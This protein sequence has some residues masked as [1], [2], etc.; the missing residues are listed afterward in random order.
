[1]N[2]IK[3]IET[4][5]RQPNF[6]G[7]DTTGCNLAANA[8][9]NKLDE[10]SFEIVEKEKIPEKYDPDFGDNRICECGHPYHRHFDSYEN[11]APVGCKYCGCY[12]F[13]E[14]TEFISDSTEKEGG[15]NLKEKILI[16]F[17]TPVGCEYEVHEVDID[18]SMASIVDNVPTYSDFFIRLGSIKAVK[19]WLNGK[20]C[21]V[22]CETEGMR[23]KAE[24]LKVLNSTGYGFIYCFD[25]NEGTVTESNGFTD[26]YRYDLVSGECKALDKPLTL[27][28]IQAK[29]EDNSTYIKGKVNVGLN[30]VINN[31]LEGFLDELSEKL[32]GDVRLMDISYK[33]VG[34]SPDG[35]TLIVEVSGDVSQ[36]LDDEE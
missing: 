11:W 15:N 19:N 31:D 33:V 14:K 34:V 24:E 29:L 4:I 1:M 25:E 36:L 7:N 35:N 27:E 22:L 5:L 23:E 28:E 18:I 8:I 20:A 13:K 6:M 21:A 3:E 10:L 12:A 17:A 30:F 2:L 9:L 32:I 26:L 16:V